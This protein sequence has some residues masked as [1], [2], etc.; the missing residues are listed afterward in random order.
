MRLT[1][2]SL[3]KMAGILAEN[4]FKFFFV[5]EKVRILITISVKFVPKGLIDNNQALV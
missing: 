1:Q 5:N 2:L 4:I 3:D